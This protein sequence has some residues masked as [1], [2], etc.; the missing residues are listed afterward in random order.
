MRTRPE[1]DSIPDHYQAGQH[2]PQRQ[3]ILIFEPGTPDGTNDITDNSSSPPEAPPI[4]SFSC[5]LP[6]NPLFSLPNMSIRI[7]IA[8]ISGYG[9][10]EL[11]RLVANHPAFELVYAAGE[12]SAGQKLIERFPGISPNWPISP[13]KNGTPPPCP[14]SISFSHPSP[15]GNQNPLSPASPKT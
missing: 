10:G 14:N 7:G 11:L 4:I 8:G 12:S 5:L 9:G 13:Y 1:A 15:P 3:P 6:Q 2:F